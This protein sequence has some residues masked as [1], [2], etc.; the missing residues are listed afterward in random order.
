LSH[1]NTPHLASSA[2]PLHIKEQVEDKVVAE[3]NDSSAFF[4]AEKGHSLVRV[5]DRADIYIKNLMAT[6]HIG[7]LLLLVLKLNCIQFS[8]FLL[9]FIVPFILS[10]SF[11]FGY[12][13]AYYPFD[14]TTM[15]VCML[16][17]VV[18]LL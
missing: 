1:A 5:V 2:H 11:L 7:L 14:P 9:L 4:V 15:Y 18:K 12:I 16:G 3:A 13:A 10:F 8:T 17:Y 6:F